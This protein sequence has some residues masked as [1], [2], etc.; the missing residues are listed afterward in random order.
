MKVKDIC[1]G[2]IVN[3]KISRIASMGNR[4]NKWFIFLTDF[5][6]IEVSREDYFKVLELYKRE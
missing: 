2:D 1:F 3:I 4:G 6:M 5:Q